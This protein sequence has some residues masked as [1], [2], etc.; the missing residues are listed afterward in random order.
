MCLKVLSIHFNFVNIWDINYRWHAQGIRSL[1]HVLYGSFPP[2]SLPLSF[3][4]SWLLFFSSFIHSLFLS[5]FLLPILAGCCY[6]SQ[7]GLRLAILLPQP[8]IRHVPLWLTPRFIDCRKISHSVLVCGFMPSLEIVPHPSDFLYIF[9]DIATL[10]FLL[11]ALFCFFFCLGPSSL[12]NF[13]L[14][15]IV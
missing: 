5:F 14:K 4:P 15:S 10:F 1:V 3:Y 7:A 13:N 9:N 8:T 6:V 2:P 11:T 12:H